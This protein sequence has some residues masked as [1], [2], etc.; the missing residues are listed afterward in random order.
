MM[1]WWKEFL[2]RL[3]HD[4]ATWLIGEDAD[5]GRLLRENAKLRIERDRLKEEVATDFLTGLLNRRGFFDRLHQ[6]GERCRRS[7]EPLTLLYFDLVGF[8]TI[9]NIA[10]HSAGDRTLEHVG[11]AVRTS[12]PQ[13]TL[14]RMSPLRRL[15]SGSVRLT[16]TLGRVGGDEFAVLLPNADEAQARRVQV[17]IAE[18]LAEIKMPGSG[19]PMQARFAAKTCRGDELARERIEEELYNPPADQVKNN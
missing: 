10:G 19:K 15:V 14:T 3:R 9:N 11:H 8:S 5:P 16:D 13:P 4:V 1:T 17:R 18:A 6:E 2:K 7:D 12:G